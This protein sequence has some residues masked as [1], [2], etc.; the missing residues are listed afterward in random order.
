MP[1]MKGLIFMLLVTSP[2]QPMPYRSSLTILECNPCR[3]A[4]RYALMDCSNRNLYKAP[5]I[6]DPWIPTQ[7]TDLFLDGNYVKDIN[8]SYW[9]Y[10]P[11]LRFVSVIQRNGICILTVIPHQIRVRGGVCANS[12]GQ[13]NYYIYI[14]HSLK[15]NK[16]I[17]C[18]ITFIESMPSDPTSDPNTCKHHNRYSSDYRTPRDLPTID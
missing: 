4:E 2:T 8:E 6:S 7:V 9:N 16:N 15:L 5:K 11:N 12:T 10:F 18:P 1:S 3:C 13:G 14:Y 17:C